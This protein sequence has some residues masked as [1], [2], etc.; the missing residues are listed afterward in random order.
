VPRV[1]L[2]SYV[3]DRLDAWKHRPAVGSNLVW[4]SFYAAVGAKLTAVRID[5][6][7]APIIKEV[8]RSHPVYSTVLKFAPR[9]TRTLEFDMLEPASATPPVIPVQP[10]VRPQQTRLTLYDGSCT[11]ADRDIER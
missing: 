7:P 10:L 6:K 9:R 11:P 1:K 4:A 3:T 8:E 5:G 2:P